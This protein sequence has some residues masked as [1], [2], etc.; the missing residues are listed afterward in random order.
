[1]VVR[2]T[3][4]FM[5]ILNQ[6]IHAAGLSLL[7]LCQ[8]G[9]FGRASEPVE[10]SA[11]AS[12]GG[13]KIVWSVDSFTEYGDKLYANYRIE[14]NTDFGRWVVLQKET[15]FPP[16]D[17]GSAYYVLPVENEGS[18]Q[19]V[20]LTKDFNYSGFRLNDKD[21]ANNDLRRGAFFEVNL[22]NSSL[23][24]SNISGV[25]MRYAVLIGT[26]FTD[27]VAIG[28]DFSHS[29][30][31]LSDL[32]GADL[33][34]AVFDYVNLR[35]VT[36]SETTVLDPKWAKVQELLTTDGIGQDLRGMDL[37][38]AYLV[39]VALDDADIRGTDFT[40]SDLRWVRFHGALMDST[41]KIGLKQRYIHQAVNDG[42]VGQF[43]NRGSWSNADL[44]NGVFTESI[45]VFADFRGSYLD[46]ADLK[47]CDLTESDFFRARA[48]GASFENAKCFMVN[49]RETDLREVNFFRAQL[50]NVNFTAANISGAD[51]TS[52]LLTRPRFHNARWNGSTLFPDPH[53]NDVIELCSG[54]PVEG[55]SYEGLSLVHANY[56]SL[57]FS[58]QSFKGS[59]FSQSL[60]D[61]T[62]FAN[63]D[64]SSAIMKSLT[65]NSVNFSGANLTGVDFTDSILRGA[66]F[67]NANLTGA[68]FSNCD[69]T[70]ANL[71]G[72][73]LTDIILKD[74]IWTDGS[75][76]SQ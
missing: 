57:D 20:R 50:S 76:R 71:T 29:N 67:T 9:V 70:G 48:P 68:N 59:D 65:G 69:L 40:D 49:F 54:G 3:L 62:S 72:A 26:D 73:D 61:G 12:D 53:W 24:A 38:R 43:N 46:N 13:V 64:L 75:Y 55:K 42:Y 10:F 41:T 14:V 34:D 58:G 5:K 28:T 56:E 19:L 45:L 1:M 8:S 17:T 39:S 27:A 32:S 25:D 33:T 31:T 63:G 23:Q 44:T 66:N 11:K 30:M 22:N 7:L 6:P 47:D 4:N 16:D 21:F 74:T 51:F 35:S 60:V 36:I 18:L 37:S 52:A 15:Q 2:V